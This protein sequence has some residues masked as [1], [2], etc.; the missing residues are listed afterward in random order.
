[1]SSR[2]LVP[3]DEY[4]ATN[5]DP[6]CDYVDGE[7]VDRNVGEKDHSKVQ[8]RLIALF[9][10]QR[11]ALGI[12]VFPEQRVRLTPTRFRIPDVCVVVGDEPDEQVFTTPPFLCIEILSPEDR[13]SRVQE[14]L[15]D[16]LNFGVPYV[17]VIDPRRRRAY[18]YSNA[19]MREV[20]GSL[21]TE[22]PSIRVSL[23]DILS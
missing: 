14:K 1:M 21:E 11:A 20:T 9:F 3:V 2:T 18:V 17:W 22:N 7:L 8:A 12:H 6:D 16:Y 5:Y 23:E 13:A 10:N 19:G 4:I 15:A